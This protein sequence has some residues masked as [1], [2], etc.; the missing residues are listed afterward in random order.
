M[1]YSRDIA[2]KRA[3]DAHRPAD[4]G[5]SNSGAFRACGR[6]K[7][8]ATRVEAK[9]AA[10]RCSRRQDAPRIHVYECP[11]C[12]GWHLTHRKA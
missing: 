7:R 12:G 8:Y 1:S 9:K 6:K 11:I 4:A 3:A 5:G 2:R 10:D